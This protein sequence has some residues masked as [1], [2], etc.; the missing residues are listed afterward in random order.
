[1]MNP[2]I[3]HTILT[4]RKYLLGLFLLYSCA[5]FAQKPVADFT[6]SPLSGCFPLKVNFFDNSTNGPTSWSWDLGNGT[7]SGNAAPSTIYLT[8]GTYTVTLIATNANGSDSVT[9]VNYITVYGNPNPNFS[10]SNTKGCAPFTTSF[11]D[12]SSTAAGT[13]ITNWEWDFGNGTIS[14]DSNPTPTFNSAGIFDITL[15][16]KNSGGCSSSI[17]KAQYISVSPALAAGFS[18]SKSV[19]CKP[20]ENIFFTNSTNGTGIM[21]YLWDFGDGATG[22]G[23]NISHNFLSGDTFII[24]LTA[25]NQFGCK[26]EH[27]DT[28]TLNNSI[29]LISGPDTVCFNT[30]ATFSNSSTPAPIRSQWYFGDSSFSSELSPTKIWAA[31]GTYIL[32][33]VNTNVN[34][35]DSATKNITV[36]T[37]PAVKFTADDTASCKIPLT[38][39]FS[40]LTPGSVSWLWDFGDTSVPSTIQ[41]PAHTYTSITS[42]GSRNVTLTITDLY[43]CVNSTTKSGYIKIFEPTVTINTGE[44]GG[45]LPYVFKAS[46]D[47]LSADGV[48]SYAWSFP[49]G[50]PVSSTD[51]TP[52]VTYNTLGTYDVILTV[53]TKDG[54]QATDTASEGV[55]TGTK[56]TVDFGVSPVALCAGA[57]F[58]FTDASNPADRWLWDFG[59]KKSDT[60]QNPTHAYEDTGRFTVKLSAWNNGCKDSVV[61]SKIVNVFPAVARFNPAYNCNNKKEVFFKDSSILPQTWAWDFGDGSTSDSS[62]PTHQFGSVQDYTVSLK[63]T[64]GICSHT[65]TQVIKIMDEKPDFILLKDSVCKLAKAYF[66]A[67]NINAANI[68]SY[69]W[70]FGDGQSDTTSVDTAFHKYNSAGTFTVKLSVIDIRG[71]IETITKPNIVQIFSPKAAFTTSVTEACAKNTIIYTDLSTTANGINNIAS[72]TWR[73]GDG[74]N[75]TI[76]APSSPNTTHGYASQGNYVASLLV[77]DS[78]GCQD[79][80]MAAKSMFITSPKAIFNTLFPKTCNNDTVPF[81]TFSTGYSLSYLWDFGDGTSSTDQYPVKLYAANGNYDVK[82]VVTDINGCKDS[83]IQVNYIDVKEVFAAFTTNDTLG[84]CIPF[85]VQLTNNSVNQTSVLW[86]YGDGFFSSN[87]N[88]THPYISSDTFLIKLTALRGKHCTSIATKKIIVDA[89]TAIISYSPLNGCTPLE[90]NFTISTRD[91]LTFEWD[92]NDGSTLATSDTFATHTYTFL[93]RN[94]K[95]IPLVL[96]KDTAKNCIIPIFGVDTIRIYSSTVN[97]SADKNLLCDNGTVQFS[98]STVSGSTVVNYSWNFGDGG[99]S[100]QQNPVHQYN[101]LGQYNVSLIITTIF[102]CKDTLVKTNFI[103]VAKKPNIAIDAITEYCG[104]SP[105]T[106]KGILLDADTSTLSWNWSFGNGNTSLLQNPPVQ[107]YT[108]TISYAVQLIATA[109]SGCTDTASVNIII[110]PIPNVSTGIDTAICLNTTAQLQATGADTYTWQPATNLSCINCSNPVA[111]PADSI[112]Y[113][114]TGTTVFNCTNS[115]AIF[116]DVKKPF[117]LTGLKAQDSICLGKSIQLS[118]SGAEIYTWSPSVGLNNTNSAS[119]A[120]SPIAGTTYKV[121]GS[122]SKNCFTDSAFIDLKVN[123]NPTVNAGEDKQ[124]LLG[125]SVPLPIQYSTDVISWLWSPATGLSCSNCAAPIATPETNTT[126]IITVTNGSK[127]TATDEVFIK[128]VCDN[129]N[130]FLPTAFTPN[131]DG[132]NDVFYPM[133]VGLFKIQSLRI[134]NRY[135]QVV[136][137]KTNVNA[138]DRSAGWDGRVNGK[139][140]D[141]GAYVYAL[142]VICK[143]GEVLTING[144]ILLIQ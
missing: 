105:V 2:K 11:T 53:T 29:P 6:A 130:L 129:S 46:A 23:R 12:L 26:D 62:N 8:P 76:N 128:V 85:K 48:A 50:N 73:F 139:I 140:A 127:C 137:L 72:W 90:V 113:T 32:K 58:N 61:K 102:G 67:T 87:Q 83:L 110:H 135:G 15:T 68:Q 109:S 18:S 93:G 95:Y 28:L 17:S 35:V 34:C 115:D 121:V 96:I 7:S 79:S 65:T 100:D 136:F 20:P 64:N 118:V 86:S 31:P 97:F 16:L 57:L 107:Q 4:N 141:V 92:F 104:A 24:K 125:N 80:I 36:I 60:K 143:N 134:F 47:V 56:P 116:I 124:L 89:P 51:S 78:S 101:T 1:M 66:T 30:P 19:K 122:D 54:C 40:D 74:Q 132:L 114:V 82:L 70:D 138:N 103:T 38:V 14:N 131:N 39:N 44:G 81:N 144:K 133:G 91:Q 49:N 22:S 123:P 142:E 75:V 42:S 126:Y 41:N 120:A 71:C 45:C 99:T 52:T 117:T 88:P 119:V 21:T 112:T 84:T 27:T 33:L 43:G 37:L 69:L 3:L 25:T 94:G 10:V 111:N 55:K 98:D 77:T 9:K 63:V 59:D 108:D 13:T 5:L 106:L